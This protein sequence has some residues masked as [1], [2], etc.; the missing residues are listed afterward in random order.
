[1]KWSFEHQKRRTATLMA[2]R[3]S[4]SRQVSSTKRNTGGW[5]CALYM[6]ATRT[7]KHIDSARSLDIHQYTNILWQ[8]YVNCGRGPVLLWRQP[9]TLQLTT[10]QQ[11][12]FTSESVPEKNIHP[13]TAFPC[14][15]YPISAL[16]LSPVDV[17][18]IES[19]CM[20]VCMSIDLHISSTCP[21][22]TKCVNCGRGSVLLW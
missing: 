14:N 22:L 3:S 9:L 6:T 11:Q 18:C 19:V 17:W 21:N 2:C 10:M 5:F 8:V 7:H 12:P 4:L 1:M 16:A 13:L 15:Y 20:S